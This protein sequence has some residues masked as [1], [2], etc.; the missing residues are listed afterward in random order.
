MLI[1]PISLEELEDAIWSYE[2]NKSRGPNGFNFNFI[3]VHW[4]MLKED[5]LGFVLEFQQNACLPKA[6]AASFIALIPKSN[7]LHSLREF[8][9]ISL[10]GCLY[11]IIV[12]IL[13]NMLKV[14]LSRII[15]PC[16]SAF[17]P[18]RQILDGALIANELVDLAKWWKDKCLLLKLDFEKAYDSVDW[19]FLEYMLIR[20]GFDSQWRNWMK[21]CIKS[22]TMSVLVNGSPTEDFPTFRGLRQGDPLALLR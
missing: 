18:H 9:P 21:A 20:M 13:A 1:S 3:K 17:L 19:G 7:N 2:G 16:Q 10:I 14:V 6:I 12:K 15:S 4:D 8:R 22:T 11:K 5:I